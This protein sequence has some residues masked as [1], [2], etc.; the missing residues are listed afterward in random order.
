MWFN[1]HEGIRFIYVHS[2][3]ALKTCILIIKCNRRKNVFCLYI[4]YY[5]GS[6]DVIHLMN[7]T[8]YSFCFA[9]CN[10]SKTGWWEGLGMRLVFN[11][12]YFLQSHA[13]L[14]TGAPTNPMS[15]TFLTSPSSLTCHSRLTSPGLSTNPVVVKLS[16][17]V[18]QC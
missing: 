9:H 15:P 5:L 13:Q 8:R 7:D 18:S 16:C 11:K 4:L 3:F 1:D 14:R 6:T 10:R 12:E 2:S 17:V